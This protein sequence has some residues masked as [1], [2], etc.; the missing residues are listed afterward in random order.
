MADAY[1]YLLDLPAGVNEM[2]TLCE[3]NDYTIYINGRLC[4]HKRREAYRHALAHIERDD[5][6]KTDV[7]Q[8]EAD[9]H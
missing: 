7:Q 9:A 2:V 5:F 8:I 6:E 3:D 1:V 4:D